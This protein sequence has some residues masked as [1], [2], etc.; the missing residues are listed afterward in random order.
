[1][2][3]YFLS[4]VIGA[5][6]ATYPPFLIFSAIMICLEGVPRLFSPTVI[7]KL[8][9]MAMSLASLK[10]MLIVGLATFGLSLWV[11]QVHAHLFHHGCHSGCG[12]GWDSG[13][14]YGYGC[15]CNSCS[16]MY[17]G[18]SWGGATLG[19]GCN[20][21]S[22][23]CGGGYWGGATL[24]C[25]WGYGNGF[26]RTAWAAVAVTPTAK[27]IAERHRIQLQRNPS[28]GRRIPRRARRHLPWRRPNLAKPRPRPHP[29][30]WAGRCLRAAPSSSRRQAGVES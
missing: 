21:C 30:R 24:G 28:T 27:R 17:G 23:M 1:M 26:G 8:R 16:G 20:T 3:L 9:R 10:K 29:Q 15:G 14:D 5:V 13:Y 11:A 22:G 18:G 4:V 19:C 25:G 6:D 12:Y 2:A 7:L